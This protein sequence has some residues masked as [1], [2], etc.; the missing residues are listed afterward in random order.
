MSLKKYCISIVY[1]WLNCLL[2]P[3]VMGINIL[4]F[5]SRKTLTAKGVVFPSFIIAVTAALFIPFHIKNGVNLQSYIISYSALIFI[6]FTSIASAYYAV[7]HINLVSYSKLISVLVLAGFVVSTI[8]LFTIGHD[9]SGWYPHSY[10]NNTN[11]FRYGGFMYEA[12]HFCL[13]ITPI[14]L[15]LISHRSSI[16]NDGYYIAALTIPLL[17]TYSAGFALT[18]LIVLLI[19]YTPKLKKKK[20][21]IKYCA[22]LLAGFVSAIILYSTVAPLQKRVDNI[23]SWQ[24]T[25]VK[26]RTLDSY[27]LALKIAGL[28]SALIGT[29]YGQTKIIG[30]NVIV[31]YYNYSEAGLDTARIPS[32]AAETLATIGVFGLALKI[33]ALLYVYI[34]FKVGATDF[35]KLLY[36]FFFTYQFYGSF[37]LSSMEFFGFAFA[38]FYSINNSRPRT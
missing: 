2:I 8:I 28:K 22:V 32:S 29:G 1:S 5:L 35:G 13:V 16:K 27:H 20:V 14:F 24:D 21:L 17:F 26:G 38:T 36:L 3:P 9:F 6:A 34:R 4:V 18:L 25:S 31:D 15:F 23:L 33:L 7:R 10:T 11:L 30:R 12:S 37:I 19:V